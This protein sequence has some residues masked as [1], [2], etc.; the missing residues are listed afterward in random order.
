MAGLCDNIDENMD[1]LRDS[2]NAP[3]IFWSTARIG[4]Q[5]YQIKPMH[6]IS[7]CEGKQTYL[8]GAGWDNLL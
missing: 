6:P 7:L 3:D 5:L 4:S 1:F 2:V 8:Q